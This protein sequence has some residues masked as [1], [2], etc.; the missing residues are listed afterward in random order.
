MNQDASSQH[1]NSEQISS[2]QHAV[3][4]FTS[5]TDNFQEAYRQLE[6]QV[7]RLNSELEE[8]NSELQTSLKEAK[9]LKEY[10]S[11]ILSSMDAGVI[12][13]DMSGRITVFNRAAED[14]TGYSRGEVLDKTYREV[15][16]YSGEEKDDPENIIKDHE[17][18]VHQEKDIIRRDGKT[19]PIKF[20][21]TLLQSDSEEP[22][23]VVEVFEDLS[24]IRKLEREIHQVGT[25]T[26]LGEMAGD[27]A[28]E[29]RNT[30]GAIAG[31]GALLERDL[32]T[33]DPRQ[34]LVRKIIVAVGKM[35]RIIGNLVFLA[36]PVIPNMR[37]V[38]IRLLLNDVIDQLD[39]QAKDDD[40][41]VDF[42][43]NFPARS[44]HIMA[45]PQL[46]QQLFLH[47]LRNSVESIDHDSGRV[48]IQ[49]RRPSKGSLGITITDNGRGIPKSL[50]ERLYR[51]LASG[52]TQ[53]AGLGL[54][55][56]RK[57]VDLHNGKIDI[58]SRLGRGTKVVLEF[59]VGLSEG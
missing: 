54:S 9:S 35:D 59:P 38:D 49:I 21:M 58:N 33:N 36:R 17:K 19:V 15:F 43:K 20:S 37:E 34:R 1:Q 50:Q 12:C 46:V 51:P 3:E 40:I 24:A 27:V 48:Q 41:K 10:L 53:R 22:L 44:L 31:F 14:L 26:A 16:G 11:N 42:V 5:A 56:V 57:I 28:H 18:T 6:R 8:K 55:I 32:G 39:F 23:G 29:I 47:L 25:L 7:A 30:L 13:T 4:F 2:L 52:G 45:D